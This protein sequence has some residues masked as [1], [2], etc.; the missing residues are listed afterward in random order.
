MFLFFVI[1]TVLNICIVGI[2]SAGTYN[3]DMSDLAMG[4]SAW[5]GE[6]KS[7]QQTP[8]N[9]ID[10]DVQQFPYPAVLNIEMYSIMPETIIA[11]REEFNLEFKIKYPN[12]KQSLLHGGPLGAATY[13]FEKIHFH[14]G[15][16]W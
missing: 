8:I 11:K 3:Y 16:S 9:I 2:N 10:S 13:L 4:P 14:W 12:N 7:L 15:D 1:L 5:P 6:C